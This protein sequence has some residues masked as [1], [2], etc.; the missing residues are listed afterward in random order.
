MTAMALHGRNSTAICHQ[1]EIVDQ[2]VDPVTQTT[3]RITQLI[4]N[5]AARARTTLHSRNT[6]TRIA[7]ARILHSGRTTAASNTEERMRGSCPNQARTIPQLAEVL[8]EV[9]DADT[10]RTTHPRMSA[11]NYV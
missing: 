1:S 9:A 7:T 8:Y 4:L 5:K 6:K 10:Q 2:G 3:K 11:K